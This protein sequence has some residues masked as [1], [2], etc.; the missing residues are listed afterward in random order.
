M[1]ARFPNTLGLV[2]ANSVINNQQS[3]Q[4]TPFIKAAVRDVKR[5]MAH[6]NKKTGGRILPV[7]Y[8]AADHYTTH[9]PGVL[10]YLAYGEEASAIDFWMVSAPLESQMVDIAPNDWMHR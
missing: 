10:E 4:V 6:C 8:A 5:F 9:I 2:V 7:A 1:M 3:L